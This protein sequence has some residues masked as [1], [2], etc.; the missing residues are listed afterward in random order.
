MS[1]T[2]QQLSVLKAAIDADPALSA[3]PNDP[4]GHFTIAAAFN[5][6]ASPTFWV[7]K[8]RLDKNVLVG[9]TGPDGT[10]FT[11]AGTGFI[12]RS[13]GE[14]AA[15]QELF[16]EGHVNPSLLNVRQ[17]FADIFSGAGQAASNRLHFAAMAR[18][19]ATRAEKLFAAGVGTTNSP[20]T[21]G[22][23]GGISPADVDSARNG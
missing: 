20:A 23:E 12:G 10:T 6:A 5:A 13:A 8:T 22:F 1:L 9:E 4:D 14:I 3:V 11:W 15:W 2:T 17:A 16:S 7:W 21:M 19:P 18:R